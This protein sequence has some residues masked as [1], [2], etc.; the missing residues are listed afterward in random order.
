MKLLKIIASIM[1]CVIVLSGC[2]N[3]EDNTINIG[4]FP[5]ITHA[6]ALVMKSK[7][8]LD[9]KLDGYNIE[10]NSFN[11]GPEEMEAVFAQKIDIGYIG[12]IP[13]INGYVK[14]NGDLAII[15]GATNAGSVLVRRKDSDIKDISDLDNKIVAIPGYGNTQH[16]CLLSLLDEN[17]LSPTSNGGT[18]NVIQSK[19]ADIVT[20]MD[21]G[22]IDAALV[23]E[24][25]GSILENTVNAEVILDY[26]KVE[27]GKD[28]STAVV[29][30]RR[31]LLKENPEIVEKF[32]SAHI[33]ATDYINENFEESKKIINE[34]I[35]NIT[36]KSIDD[37]VL[38][39]AFSRMFVTYEIP[40][41]S[42]EEFSQLDLKAGFIKSL[43]DENIIVSEEL[44][45]LKNK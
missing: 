36:K 42:I 44:E 12:P 8:M 22:D 41:K 31:D 20:L 26:S 16:L 45:K 5:N 1:L 2:S 18:V 35:Y 30:V 23:P 43:P 14:S 38:E 24:P 21:K 11:A 15:A 28:Y 10:W 4:Y 6:Q 32:L 17:N 34:E 40:K 39:K 33:E 27:N 7:K 19:N 13:A 3:S 29:I 37:D 25:W 9:E